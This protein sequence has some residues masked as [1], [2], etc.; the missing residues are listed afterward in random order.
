MTQ[1]TM[2]TLVATDLA[3]A[4]TVDAS[5][6]QSR[7]GCQSVRLGEWVTSVGYAFAERAAPP[8][9]DTLHVI[10][11]APDEK[12]SP[13]GCDRRACR[14]LTL[15]TPEG[16]IVIEVGRSRA[17]VGIETSQWIASAGPILLAISVCWRFEEIERSLDELTTWTRS[18]LQ[19][20]ERRP[21]GNRRRELDERFRA[22]H[23]L[24]VDLPC[25]EG[26]LDDP[27]GYFPSS[28][29]TRL[30]RR[31]ARRLRLAAWRARLD[32]RIEILESAVDGLVDTQ[33]H[34]QLLRWEIAL[35]S[36]ILL[37]L[38]TDIGIHLAL[39]LLE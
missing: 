9:S 19:G 29:E 30:Y 6:L 12:P 36:L 13:P 18:Q 20:S 2:R 33:R 34:R 21:T 23:A 32:E 5:W 8:E 39:A 11:A 28:A 3:R 17:R 27:G 37:A 38:V 24:I 10:I 31:L 1:S 4:K 14:Q 26:S 25:F 35:E 15:E 22:L 7:M 16:Q